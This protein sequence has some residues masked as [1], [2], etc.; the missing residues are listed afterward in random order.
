MCEETGEGGVAA[1][2]LASIELRFGTS[3]TLLSL[4]CPFFHYAGA[5]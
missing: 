2:G 4:R 5:V 3:D 1:A